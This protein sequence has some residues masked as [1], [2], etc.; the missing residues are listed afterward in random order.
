MTKLHCN[1][2]FALRDIDTKKIFPFPDH[3]K[4]SS[5]IYEKNPVSRRSR[6]HDLPSRPLCQKMLYPLLMASIT[7]PVLQ[8]MLSGGYGSVVSVCSKRI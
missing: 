8:E 3:I 2:F 1:T 5:H 7:I 6:R 4:V